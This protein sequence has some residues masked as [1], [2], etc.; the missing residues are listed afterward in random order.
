M[1]SSIAHALTALPVGAAL[2]PKDTPRRVWIAGLACAVVPDIDAIGRPFV[3]GD[4]TF[5]GGHRA[6]T[7]SLPFAIALSIVV[8]GS[9]CRHSTSTSECRWIAAFL[10]V[11]T[12]SHGLL[13]TLTIYGGGV[14]LLAPFSM[15]RYTAPWHPLNSLN[16]IT[17]IWLPAL[18][19]FGIVA[20][21]RR[22]P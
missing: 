3:L 22:N 16:E 2:L 21:L 11:A 4:L 20:L 13:D 10:F 6:L 9:L 12:A 17:W 15:Q 19:V 7:H 8:V 5:L 18:V 14:A 1:P